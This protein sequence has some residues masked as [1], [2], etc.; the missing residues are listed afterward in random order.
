MV[1]SDVEIRKAIETGLIKFEPPLDLDKQVQ[2]ASVDLR[3]GGKVFK[4]VPEP[5][6]R[7]ISEGEYLVIE[8]SEFVEVLTYERIELSNK[9]V[10]R[11]GL[12]SEFTRK[13]LL[14]FS[15]PQID[16]GFRG[17]LSVSLY[18]NSTIP[19]TIK[20]KETFC[21]IEF[22]EL[23]TPSSF[24]YKGRYQDQKDFDSLDI[25]WL[26]TAK[27]M[28]FS[29]VVESIKNLQQSVTLLD[30]TVKNMQETFTTSV[31][32]LRADVRL[33]VTL[34]GIIVALISLLSRI[35]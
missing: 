24:P 26:M 6:V 27:G 32:S 35:L 12:R 34:L 22:S 8:P 31:N 19:V 5:G 17:V 11:I 28:T 16:P 20:F 15:G 21:T 2:P 29:Q 30:T 13:G 4:T 25:S 1:M 9:V 14:L 23:D 18:N 7:T 3:L 10:G 33:Y